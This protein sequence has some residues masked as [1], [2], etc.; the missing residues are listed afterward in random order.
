MSWSP[1]NSGRNWNAAHLMYPPIPFWNLPEPSR[2]CQ[3]ISPKILARLIESLKDTL[4]VADT[5]TG[6]WAANEQSDLVHLASCVHHKAFG[7]VT[8]D[9]RILRHSGTLLEKYK[10]RVI[11][12]LDLS[13]SFGEV[14]T[15]RPALSVAVGQKEIKVSTLDDG[16]D[17]AAED[18]LRKLGINETTISYCLSPGTTQSPRTRLVVQMRDVIV[19]IASWEAKVGFTG[20]SQAYLYVEEENPVSDKAID[21]LLESMINRGNFGTDVFF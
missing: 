20:N 18:F 19:G 14:E 5:R 7:F 3:K 4:S 15:Y 12:P 10:L 11:S 1:L 8:R 16:I 17:T 13:E 2:P 21:H 9:A 6:K